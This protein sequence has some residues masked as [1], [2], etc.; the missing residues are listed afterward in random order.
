VSASQCSGARE[1]ARGGRSNVT[2]HGPG[3]WRT[4]RDVRRRS[5]VLAGGRHHS[6]PSN[7]LEATPRSTERQVDQ[8]LKDQRAWKVRPWTARRNFGNPVKFGRNARHEIG[9]F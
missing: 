2:C 5:G 9:K 1:C 8:C 7:Q 6:L 4:A 3:D